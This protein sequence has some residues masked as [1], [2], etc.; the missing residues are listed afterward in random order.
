MHGAASLLKWS[1]PYMWARRTVISVGGVAGAVAIAL[2]GG[3]ALTRHVPVEARRGG[4][5]ARRGEQRALATIPAPQRRAWCDGAVG[6]CPPPL[7]R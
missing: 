5:H 6:L 7:H 4:A 1:E 3:D 2:G